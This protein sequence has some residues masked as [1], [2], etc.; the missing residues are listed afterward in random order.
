MSRFLCFALLGA[1]AGC[2]P[3]PRYAVVDVVE[4][5]PQA[6]PVSNALVATDCGKRFDAAART[7]EDG[8]AR[9]KLWG[10]PSADHCRLLVAKPGFTTVVTP[11]VQLCDHLSP[12]PSTLVALLAEVLP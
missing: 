2:P 7:D 6:A 3:P 8:H 1:L 11:I 10:T 4:Q 9:V 12:C 5:T